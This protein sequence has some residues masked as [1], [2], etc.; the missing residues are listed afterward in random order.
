[1][2]GRR[3]KWIVRLFLLGSLA[4]SAWFWLAGPDIAEESY[5]DLNISGSYSEARPSGLLGKPQAEKV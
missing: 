4:F 1:M 5:L 2:L 3:F